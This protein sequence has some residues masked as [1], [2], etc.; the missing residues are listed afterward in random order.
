M[1]A[2]LV[3]VSG[4]RCEQRDSNAVPNCCHKPQGYVF[5]NE[6]TPE[7]GGD[8]QL[9]VCYLANVP[10]DYAFRPKLPH[11]YAPNLD[12]ECLRANV[13]QPTTGGR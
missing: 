5:A 11:I 4:R 2:P 8:G 10:N 7:T 9:I 13:R 12:V 6:T 1:G 3:A